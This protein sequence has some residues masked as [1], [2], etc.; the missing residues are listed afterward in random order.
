MKRT[1]IVPRNILV[2]A[3]LPA[4]TATYT[5][6]SHGFIINSILQTL[7]AKG[8]TVSKEQYTCSENAQIAT[9]VFH[10]NYGNDPDLGMLFAF[11]N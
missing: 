6:I 9:G 1:G 4:A 10:I 11:S 7:N 8:F 3:A 2:D 5:V